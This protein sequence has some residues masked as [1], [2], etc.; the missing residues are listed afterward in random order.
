MNLVE[1]AWDG[2][3]EDSSNSDNSQNKEDQVVM[4]IIGKSGSGKSYLTR[5]LMAQF[6]PDKRPI[7]VVNDRTRNKE[8]TKVEWGRVKDL[9]DCG[10][11]IE[12][13]INITNKELEII[14]E[15]TNWMNN[16][17]KLNP[18]AI[19]SHSL[20]RTRM[21]GILPYISLIYISAVKSS[22]VSLRNLLHYYSFEP[23]E[24]KT[25]VDMLLKC[26]EPYSHMLLNVETRSIVMTRVE[27]SVRNAEER[28]K[29]LAERELVDAPLRRFSA[30]QE[31]ARKYLGKI[32]VNSDYAIVL[33]DLIFP[34]LPHHRYNERDMTVQ[35]VRGGQPI[36]INLIDYLSS[37]VSE[38]EEDLD[39]ESVQFHKYLTRKK[40]LNL[41]KTL[42]VN[43]K[44]WKF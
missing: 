35:L 4:L 29:Q 16:H 7:F 22:I 10:L 30:A 31:Q 34:V 6:N 21:Y 28:Q 32:R 17:K 37:L 23:A 12:D 11:I 44:F 27:S 38:S 1:N 8:Y 20:M 5:S 36:T 39:Y 9:H 25:Y 24:K 42:V 19:I 3:N 13:A 2:S 14:K 18:L 43:R 40:K 26:N 33:F 15:A 41:P